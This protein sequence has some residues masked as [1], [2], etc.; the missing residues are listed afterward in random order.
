MQA[1]NNAGP[2]A[3]LDSVVQGWFHPT[4]NGLQCFT[5]RMGFRL[6]SPLPP[7]VSQTWLECCCSVV[8]VLVPALQCQQELT[9][10]RDLC[11]CASAQ[12]G[13]CK[14]TH[15]FS[16]VN[17]AE[18]KQ[19]LPEMPWER[20]WDFPPLCC[21]GEFICIPYCCLAGGADAF[22]TIHISQGWDKPKPLEHFQLLPGMWEQVRK[23]S[24]AAI[25]ME[26]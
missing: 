2:P 3:E 14:Y 6:L 18:C 7:L 24:N 23:L 22:V 1:G 16:L 19:A 15:R 25:F 13:N 17:G 26:S 4:C 12:E 9:R 11:V 10:H 20:S 8:P 21:T 5:L